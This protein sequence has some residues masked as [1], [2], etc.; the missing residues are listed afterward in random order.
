VTPLGLEA[1][2]V[3]G[4]CPTDG[5][6][7]TPQHHR[8][9]ADGM[10]HAARHCGGT[11]RMDITLRNLTAEDA[12]RLRPPGLVPPAREERRES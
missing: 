4:C 3:D 11:L 6:I 2:A 7:G 12:A 10:V 5:S 1:R 8:A 9:Q